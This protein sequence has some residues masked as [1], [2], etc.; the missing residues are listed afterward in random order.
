MKT[1][2]PDLNPIRLNCISIL[3][4]NKLCSFQ[5]LPQEEQMLKNIDLLIL[6]YALQDS[7]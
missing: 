4:I 6:P 7:F 3:T 2:L 5:L 1:V